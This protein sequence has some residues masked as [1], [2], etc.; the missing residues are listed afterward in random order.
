MLRAYV[1]FIYCAVVCFVV[2]C[3]VALC[4]LPRLRS[5]VI[6][7]CARSSLFVCVCTLHWHCVRRVG[8]Q[9]T[10]AV[11]WLGFGAMLAHLPVYAARTFDLFAVPWCVFLCDAPPY[12]VCCRACTV[13]LLHYVRGVHC[14]C[15]FALCAVI[16]R[17][18]L[19]LN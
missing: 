18:G 13:V 12:C 10:H 5:C 4:L 6:A 3:T 7:L 9:S 14:L 19:F 8:S 11:Q 17:A 2:T 15:A 16:M 1:C